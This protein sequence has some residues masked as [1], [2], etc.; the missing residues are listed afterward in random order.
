[1][2]ANAMHG[3]R[4]KYI[5]LGMDGYVSKP[6]KIDRLAV[7]IEEVVLKSRITANASN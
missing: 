6:V 5:A 3:D 1:M 7:E 2:T 4:E